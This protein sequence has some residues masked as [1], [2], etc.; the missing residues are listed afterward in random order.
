MLCRIRGDGYP[1]IE[2]YHAAK[3][4]PRKISANSDNA[5]ERFSLSFFV[6]TRIFLKAKGNSLKISFG[7][8]KKPAEA[9]LLGNSVSQDARL[10][11]L[12]WLT[13]FPELLV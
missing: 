4:L 13:A 2:G 3:Q 6:R 10:S 7:D 9:S 11:R 12:N 8:V 1:S 5:N